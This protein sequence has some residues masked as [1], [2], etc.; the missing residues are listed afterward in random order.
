LQGNCSAFPDGA[1]YIDAAHPYS[2]DLDI[3]GKGSVYQ[4]V[5]RAVT[6][7]GASLLAGKLSSLTLK[8]ED[9][10]ERQEIIKEL[11][12]QPDLLQNFR[13][14]GMVVAEG[15]GDQLFL[16][17]WLHEKDLFINNSI[18]RVAAVLMPLLSIAG[19]LWSVFIG[20]LH[21]GLSLVVIANWVLLISF[22]KNIKLSTRQ[23]DNSAK[24]IDKY[25]SLLQHMTTCTFK[26][27]WLQSTS[28]NAKRSLD[29]ITG[30][31]KIVHLFESRSNA[32]TGMLMNTQSTRS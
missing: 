11:S 7:G 9:I 8:K 16:T 32:M 4:S 25:E 17:Q 26:N 29:N 10:T 27:S 15:T 28:A 18:I 3:F 13:V 22:Q 14:A 20:G 21:P 6:V 30:L 2:Y 12:T 23:I 31:K 24:F 5:C 1:A 19:L